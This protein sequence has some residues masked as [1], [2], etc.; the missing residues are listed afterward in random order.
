MEVK[1]AKAALINVGLLSVPKPVAVTKKSIAITS[2]WKDPKD[3]V[4]YYEISASLANY[5]WTV[6][7]RFN[8][9]W[10][11]NTKLQQSHNLGLQLPAK[12]F[13]SLTAPE[14]DKRRES[15]HQYLEVRTLSQPRPYSS[16]I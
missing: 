7:R 8:D 1:E 10:E 15:L 11:L 12:T 13:G 6:K 3:G 2:S 4:V 14:L 9:F 16:T 5:E